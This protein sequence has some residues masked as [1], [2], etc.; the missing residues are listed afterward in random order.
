[1]W[2]FCRASGFVGVESLNR[3]GSEAGAGWRRKWMS[4]LR[5]EIF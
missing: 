5:G 3:V 4:F 2:W 1:M